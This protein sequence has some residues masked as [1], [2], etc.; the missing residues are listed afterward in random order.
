M[1]SPCPLYPHGQQQERLADGEAKRL[2][3]F[4]IDDQFKFGPG[5]E[6]AELPGGSPL[7]MRSTEEAERRKNIG[8]IGPIIAP[9]PLDVVVDFIVRAFW[10]IPA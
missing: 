1:Q 10:P 6:L 5:I 4:K 2:D 8:S 9:H 7:R 3:L